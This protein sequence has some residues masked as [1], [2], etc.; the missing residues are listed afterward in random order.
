MALIMSYSVQSVVL[1]N[2]HVTINLEI[3]RS[4]SYSVHKLLLPYVINGF[5]QN[6]VEHFARLH[7]RRFRLPATGYPN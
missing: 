1:Y 6:N 3:F 2:R 7:V 4:G 5:V